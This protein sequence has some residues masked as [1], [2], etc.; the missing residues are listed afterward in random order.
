MQTSRIKQLYKKIALI[1]SV[2]ALI[3]WCI[4]GAGA[5]LAWFADT[6]PE[7]N[8]IF[9]FADFNVEV[10]H[11]LTDGTWEEVDSQTQIFDDKVNYEPGY[12]QVAYLKIKNTGTCKFQFNTAVNVTGYTPATNI[13]GQSFNLQDYLKFG[14]VMADSEEAMKNSVPT[15]EAANDIANEKLNRYATKTQELDVGETVYVAVIV[16]MPAEVGNMA[17][18]QG[19]TGPKVELGIIVKADQVQ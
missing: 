9:H 17:N 16:R 5:S 15:R 6:S 13:F 8:N 2:S 11:R 14:L 18:Y 1:F 3:I 4:L 10:S 19:T 12:V 7:I